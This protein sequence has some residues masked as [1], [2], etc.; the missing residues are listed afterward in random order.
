[1]NRLDSGVGIKEGKWDSGP[2]GQSGRKEIVY[3]YNRWALSFRWIPAI[4][5]EWHLGCQRAK[6]WVDV[7]SE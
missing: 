3:K 2:R 5:H 4:P 7:F 6:F 1:V